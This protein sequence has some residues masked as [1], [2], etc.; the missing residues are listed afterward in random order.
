MAV[1]TRLMSDASIREGVPPPKNID[2]TM[3]LSPT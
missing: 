1:I 3:A 2:G